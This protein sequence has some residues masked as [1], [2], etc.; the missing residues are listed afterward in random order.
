MP[1]ACRL[2]ARSRHEPDF[3]ANLEF[4]KSYALTSQ[5]ELD[6]R[7][8]DQLFIEF[9]HEVRQ[10]IDHYPGIEHRNLYLGRSWDMLY[11]L[12]SEGRRKG[13]PKDWTHWVE[14]A[15]F[16]GEILNEAT[17][18]TIGFPIRYLSP[19]EVCHVQDKLETVTLE[20]LRSHWNPQAMREAE[21][22]KIHVEE[23][24]DCCKWVQEDFEKL[25][26]F[27]ALS[28]GHGEGVL[29]FVG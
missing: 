4:F 27:Y 13:E 3:G 25:R 12:L 21:I 16:G 24:E 10:A 9:V 26:A 18:T 28:A 1:D 15:I 23:N 19:V 5:E 11:Y 6:H 20:M 17:Q 29:A 22:Y 2:L 8:N 7:A 14:K